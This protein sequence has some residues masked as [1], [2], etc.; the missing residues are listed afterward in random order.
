MSEL[1]T[2]KQ[3]RIRLMMSR[4]TYMRVKREGIVSETNVNGHP[5]ISWEENKSRFIASAPDPDRYLPEAIQKRDKKR[6]LRESAIDSQRLARRL[7]NKPKLNNLP[8]VSEVK[9]AD[10]VKL[11]DAEDEDNNDLD[12][13]EIM[14]DSKQHPTM[15]RRSAEAVKQV[16]LAKQAKLRFLRD[17]GILMETTAVIEE[18]KNLATYMRKQLLA[19]PD[20]ICEL[21]VNM[22]AREIHKLILDELVHVMT[23]MRYE[24]KKVNGTKVTKEDDDD[25]ERFGTDE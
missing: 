25:L 13:N 12:M 2:P 11:N 6:I 9:N 16:Y 19:I 23:G 7:N 24:I 3:F 20:R 4:P 15:M 8:P 17:A 18:W 22:S 5:M 14:G 10:P 1:I 21:C